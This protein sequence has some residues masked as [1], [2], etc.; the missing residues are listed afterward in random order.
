MQ[1]VLD[2]L[3][4]SGLVDDPV[5]VADDSVLLGAGSEL[6]SLELVTLIAELEER[7]SLDTGADTL[8]VLTDIH[9]FNADSLALTASTLANYISQ[10]TVG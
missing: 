7:L 2:G 5:A 4:R 6:D 8:L 3:H 10:Q 1:D 9:E